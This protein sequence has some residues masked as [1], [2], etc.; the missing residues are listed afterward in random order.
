MM[1]Y[2]PFRLN[3]GYSTETRRIC[4]NIEHLKKLTNMSYRKLSIEL[5]FKKSSLLNYVT[6]CVRPNTD[7]LQV[8]ADYFGVEHIED[9]CMDEKKFA[10]KYPALGIRA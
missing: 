3:L 10:I 7:R 9:F 1:T 8:I 5:G 2:R 6:G 4:N